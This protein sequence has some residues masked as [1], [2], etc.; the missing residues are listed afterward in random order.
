MIPSL[1]LVSLAI[2]NNSI[3]LRL[4]MKKRKADCSIDDFI[5]EYLKK[6]KCVGTLKLFEKNDPCNVYESFMNY[7]RNIETEKV[8]VKDELGFEINFEAYQHKVKVSHFK[9]HITYCILY[10]AHIKIYVMNHVL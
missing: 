8:T 9:T 1:I 10:M 4:S 3:I 2:L 5:V 7:L 6:K